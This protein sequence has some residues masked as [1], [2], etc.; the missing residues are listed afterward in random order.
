MS[1]TG[2]D[3]PMLVHL[4]Q[5]IR[6]DD[7]RRQAASFEDGRLSVRDPIGRIKRRTATQSA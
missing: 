3:D 4:W 7:L 1:D 2:S 6:L 5:I